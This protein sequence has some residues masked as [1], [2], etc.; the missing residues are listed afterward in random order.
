ME[1]EKQKEEEE[2]EEEATKM[3]QQGPEMVLATMPLAEHG[4]LVETVKE[5]KDDT[6]A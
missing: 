5:G 3:E 6:P 1:Q 4:A 2:E